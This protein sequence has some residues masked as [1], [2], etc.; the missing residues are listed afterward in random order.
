MRYGLA[1]LAVDE[2]A[3]GGV[4]TRVFQSMLQ[5]MHFSSTI[6]TSIC[7]GP[8]EMGG[9]GIYNLR[10]EA[11]LKALKFFRNSLYAQTETGNLLRLNLEYSQREAGIGRALLQHPGI[12][13]PYLTPSWIL[14]LRQYLFLHNMSV[15][16]T[17]SHIDQLRGPTDQFIMDQTHLQRYSISQQRGINLVRMHL[18]VV[19]LSDMVD[20]DKPNRINVSFLDAQRKVSLIPSTTRPRQPEITASQRR[21]W[22]RFISSSFL[23]YIPYWSTSPPLTPSVPV[24]P[25]TPTRHFET[26]NEY[27]RSL[28]RTQRRLLDG[29]EQVAS[30]V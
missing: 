29:L 1:A 18:Q 19:T 6:P 14:S 20:R 22:K 28:P 27:I 16:V 2:E 5:K 9:L 10:T 3:L 7:H 21:L 12:H 30:D 25:V 17:N 11:G 24:T 23:R 13:L 8:V 26:L 15:I 4:Q